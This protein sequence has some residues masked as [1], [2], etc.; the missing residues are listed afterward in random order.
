MKAEAQAELDKNR[1]AHEDPWPDVHDRLH[2]LAV[3]RRARSKHGSVGL[4]QMRRRD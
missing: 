1:R 4:Q 3:D 2:E